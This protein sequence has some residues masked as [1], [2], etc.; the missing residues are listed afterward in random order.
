MSV[1]ENND[2]C[3][4]GAWTASNMIHKLSAINSLRLSDA[5]MHW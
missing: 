5:H 3:Y 2:L 1:F 4:K